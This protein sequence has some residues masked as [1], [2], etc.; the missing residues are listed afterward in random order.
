MK[1]IR[2]YNKEVF[3]YGIVA[4][5]FSFIITVSYMGIWGT[6][7]NVPVTAYRGDSLGV[8]L[9]AN[10]YLRGGD[11]HVNVFFAAPNIGGY[12]YNLGDSSMPIPFLGLMAKIF[13]SLEAAV[14]IH[15]ILN[16]LLMTVCMYIICIR[17]GVR[18]TVAAVAGV[19]YS[20]LSYFAIF[21]ST[22]LLIYGACFYIPLFC[23]AI[24]EIMRKNKKIGIK[25][26][27]FT[28]IVM[29]YVGLNS[30]YYAFFTLLILL[31]VGM[32]ALLY[33][34]DVDK[35]LVVFLSYVA[36]GFG[37]AVYT[38]PNILHNAFQYDALW[39]SGYYYP[40]CVVIGIV[41]SII[42]YF[43]YKI[44]R[45]RISLKTIWIFIGAVII[46]GCG[47][48]AFLAKYTDFL[49]EYGGRSIEQVQAMT[50]SL[51]NTFLPAVNTIWKGLN[52][53]LRILVS[54]ENNDFTVLGVLAGFG[55]LASIFSVFSYKEVE[56]IQEEILSICGKC[57]F[58][59]IAIA[60]KGGGSLLIAQ[61][62][63]T[64]I[65]YYSRMCIFI[66]CFS[67]ISFA[68]CTEKI[69]CKIDRLG[70][71][72][73]GIKVGLWSCILLGISLSI[74]TSIINKNSY[75][76]SYGY[77]EY[78]QRKK[79]YDS[80]QTLIQSIEDQMPVNSMILQLPLNVDT[81][82]AVELMIHGQEYELGIPLVI[83]KSTCWSYMGDLKEFEGVDSIEDLL[84]KAA[85]YNF[86]GVY[87]DTFM[88]A[89]KEYVDVLKQLE[90]Y[91]GKP[92]VCN[93]ERRFFFNM[94]NY[95]KSIQTLYTDEELEIIR[96]GEWL[97]E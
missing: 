53:E 45:P 86:Q 23:Y 63:T 58:F 80:W 89:D 36:I 82:Y 15:A 69:L 61:F 31:F 74:P 54:L 51:V 14:N 95:T 49:G 11:A 43:F 21:A 67:L 24:I 30:A 56:D 76:N 17:W 91:L 34:K 92:I 72:K 47:V 59:I 44:I 85:A 16:C 55:F 7:I 22:H 65:R 64:G 27:I 50:Y 37:I 29:L 81:E 87:V 62:I 77:V 46:L 42:G 8:L 97:V 41:I 13:G 2:N 79:E 32:Y 12:Y 60:V 18:G 75:G 38:V 70:K 3:L 52:N 93:E 6:D 33:L 1:V 25:N 4:V 71:I 26:L 40:V 5:I 88:Y 94:M 10:N 78:E 83:S 28:I 20:S 9:E 90:T 68:L 73:Y 66:A 35:V 84:L 96:N 19:C 48:F 39:N 57:N